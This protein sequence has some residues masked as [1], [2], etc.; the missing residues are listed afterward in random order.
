MANRS[1]ILI[2]EDEDVAR[3]NLE[4]ILAKGEYEIEAVD[5]GMEALKRFERDT[6]DLVLTDLRLDKVDGMEVLAKI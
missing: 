6:Y 4:H 2:V 5:S 1:R 3:K